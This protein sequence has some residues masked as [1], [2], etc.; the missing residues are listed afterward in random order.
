MGWWIVTY[1]ADVVVEA[2]DEEEAAEA[3]LAET[4]LTTGD[5]FIMDIVP[6]ETEEDF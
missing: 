3:A 5:I 1:S 2:F 6:C 4:T